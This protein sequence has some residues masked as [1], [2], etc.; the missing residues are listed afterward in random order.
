MID[1]DTEGEIIV[2]IYAEIGLVVKF[3]AQAVGVER[4]AVGGRYLSGC[5][6]I[7]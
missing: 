1:R 4:Q 5:R 7:T 2:F 3:A 6:K